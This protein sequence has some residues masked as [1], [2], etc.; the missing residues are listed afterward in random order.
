MIPLFPRPLGHEIS[1]SLAR[2]ELDPLLGIFNKGQAGSS[3]QSAPS[4][5]QTPQLPSELSPPTYFAMFHVLDRRKLEY[6]R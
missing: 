4:L 6:A 1:H 3:A 5:N 2:S